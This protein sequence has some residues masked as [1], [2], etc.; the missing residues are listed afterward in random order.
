MQT[1]ILNDETIMDLKDGT[2]LSYLIALVDN[3]AGLA[4]LE[5][6]LMKKGNLDKVRFTNEEG[7]VYKEY[8]NMILD[9]PLFHCVDTADGKVE[10]AFSI[11]EKTEIEK[12]LDE[13]EESQ[14]I[15]DGAVVELA[16]I[17]GGE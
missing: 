16:E 10:A 11:R 1:M 3:Y 4:D 9:L 12:R 6:A 13:L 7:D 14:S 15:T 2:C 8:E 17:I 5:N